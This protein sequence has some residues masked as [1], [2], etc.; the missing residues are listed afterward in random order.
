MGQQCHERPAEAD[1]MEVVMGSSDE[2]ELERVIVT[3]TTLVYSLRGILAD[4][5]E[6]GLPEDGARSSLDAIEMNTRV[7]RAALERHGAL[8]EERNLPR[9]PDP[10]DR[11][12]SVLRWPPPWIEQAAG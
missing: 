7:L 8:L 11:M 12:V 6:D 10:L 2:A 9:R 5:A 1:L 3:T 4:L